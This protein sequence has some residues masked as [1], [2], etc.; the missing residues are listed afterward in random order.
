MTGISKLMICMKRHIFVYNYYYRIKVKNSYFHF[1]NVNHK[2]FRQNHFKY[3]EFVQVKVA[4][5]LHVCLI[6]RHIDGQASIPFK[7]TSCNNIYVAY[8]C[9]GPPYGNANYQSC[10]KDH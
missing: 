9:G 2:H 3:F 8:K 1:N 5:K 6:N 7:V 10:L 4:R